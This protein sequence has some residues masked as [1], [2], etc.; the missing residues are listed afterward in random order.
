MTDKTR[1]QFVT[2]V[3]AGC[4][5]VPLAGLVSA[6]PSRAQ[7]QDNPMVDPSSAQAKALQY[8]E[9]SEKEGQMCSNCTL[10]KG[11]DGS[12]NG[13]CSL[14]PGMNVTAS[15]WCSAYVAKA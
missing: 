5:A 14:F 7:A 15:G 4:A 11:D 8:V 9:S 6:L 13:P 1:R 10:Y 2:L 12:E 3:G